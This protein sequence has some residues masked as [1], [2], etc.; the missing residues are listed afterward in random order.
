MVGSSTQLIDST[1]LW[2]IRAGSVTTDGTPLTPGGISSPELIK[3]N[4]YYYLFYSAGDWCLSTF[5]TGVARSTNLF[6][7]YEKMK[8]PLLSNGVVGRGRLQS[9]DTA[10]QLLSPGAATILQLDA[11]TFRIVYHAVLG[12][13]T[14]ATCNNKYP[15]MNPLKFDAN[16]WPYVEFY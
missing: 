11:D 5:V 12:T 14:A 1:G 7:P 6:G 16:G 4:G 2:W 3:Y 8:V 10:Q 15:Y 13:A 9:T